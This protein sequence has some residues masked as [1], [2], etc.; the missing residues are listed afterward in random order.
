MNWL[1]AVVGQ[2]FDDLDGTCMLHLR[3]EIDA[4]AVALVRVEIDVD[5]A[6]STIDGNE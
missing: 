3:Q 6:R 2:Q 5:L 1:P 4:A